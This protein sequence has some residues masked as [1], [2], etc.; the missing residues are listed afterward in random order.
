ML[1]NNSFNNIVIIIKIKEQKN[2][3]KFVDDIKYLYNE[4]FAIYNDKMYI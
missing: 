4:L 2:R 3:S 1:Y